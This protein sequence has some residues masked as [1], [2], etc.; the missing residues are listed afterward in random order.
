MKPKFLFGL[1]PLLAVAAFVVAPAA[2]QAEVCFQNTEGGPCITESEGLVATSTS[3]TLTAPAGSVTC[4]KVSLEGKAGLKGKSTITK[5]KWEGC[6]T[7]VP[8]CTV[9][10]TQLSN[11]TDQLG[12]SKAAGFTDTITIPGPTPEEIS[13][14]FA[15]S[16]CPLKEAGDI[17]VF[18]SVTGK[19]A[20]DNPSTLT[21]TKATGLHFGEEEATLTGTF[22]VTRANGKNI[23]VSEH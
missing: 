8:G 22:S 6:T 19:W 5:S 18:G 1:A 17:P 9:T 15:G 7:T 4:T 12:G 3:S 21:F 20:N 10:V 23:F 2:A 16:S 11:L 13:I 14:Q